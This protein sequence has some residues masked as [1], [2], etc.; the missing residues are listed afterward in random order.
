MIRAGS[1]AVRPGRARNIGFAIAGFVLMA[2]GPAAYAQSGGLDLSGSLSNDMVLLQNLDGGA[3]GATAPGL[4]NPSVGGF[5]K[6]TLNFVN[7]NRSSAKVEGSVALSLLYGAYSDAYIAALS[8]QLGPSYSQVVTL[9]TSNGAAFNLDLRKLYLSVYTNLMDISVGR[10]II[11]Y[12]VG[13]LFSPIDAFSTPTL[14]DLNYERSGSDVVRLQLPFG[15]VSGVDA[16]TTVSDSL[17]GLTSAVKL[18]TNI[19][20][21]DVGAVGLYRGADREFIA[22]IDFKGDLVL[23]IHG[24][25]VQHFLYDSRKSFFEGMFGA[26][27]SF[28]GKLFLSA[29]YYYNGDPATPGSLGPTAVAS[30]RRLFLNEHYLYSDV[31]YLLNE[32]SSVGVSGVFDLSAGSLLGTAQYAYNIAQNADLLAYVRY[33]RGDVRSG[34]SG[35]ST[36]QY[37]AELR[38]AF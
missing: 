24:E 4:S 1:S 37:G 16:V 28:G 17:S 22:G 35:G 32:L 5:S 15:D 7:R 25:A 20:D 12:G 8:S 14:S 38:V 26:D 29:E 3:P 9:L 36:F 31:R 13:T 11:N 34:I 10:Q 6:F 19:A 21:Y 2:I 33:F 18:Y 23:G 27:Y 30:A